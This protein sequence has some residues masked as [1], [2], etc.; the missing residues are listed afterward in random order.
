MNVG[1][2]DLQELLWP[3]A[4]MPER[5]YSA[6]GS[7]GRLDAYGNLCLSE[8][9]VF[10]GNAYFNAFFPTVWRDRARLG[11]VGLSCRA[12]GRVAMRLDGHCRDGSIATVAAWTQTAGMDQNVHWFW[13]DG[14]PLD[15]LRL[16]LHL[17]AE[18]EASVERVA[19]VTTRP[20][21]RDIRLTIGIVTHDREGCLARTLDA[22]TAG[23]GTLPELQR[24]VLVNQGP[25]FRDLPLREKVASPL[26]R[27]IVQPNLG[28]CGGFTRT[29]VEAMEDGGGATHLLLM[30]DDIRLD[31]RMIR[32]AIDFARQS[33]G[34]VAIGAQ[35][36]ELE[37][38]E[39]LQEAW[40]ALGKGWQPLMAG[41]GLDM[42]KPEG[43]CL[44]DEAVRPD[45]NGWWFCVIPTEAIRE[46]GLPV[47]VFIRG[48]DIEYGL[49]LGRGGWP[50]VALPGLAVWHAS[51]HYKHVG[52]AQYYEQRNLLIAAVAHRQREAM[53]PV[54]AVLG[55]CVHHLL[56][57]R[58]RAAAANALALSDFLAGPEA[59][60]GRN[61]ALRHREVA[62]WMDRLPR[63][64]RVDS[65][66]SAGLVR[67]EGFVAGRSTPLGAGK[68]VALILRILLTST[69]RP[70]QHLQ[71]GAPDPLAIQ[72]R[73]YLLA[74]DPGAR[75]C[76]A[77]RARR[78]VFLRI[79]AAAV[80]AAF[81]YWLFGPRSVER[82][83]ERL[84][85]LRSRDRW[86]R[87][88][89]ADHE[90]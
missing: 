85:A 56:A 34:S 22:I 65:P 57:H 41:T 51:T 17:R 23:A 27:L 68:A 73:P 38:P 21:Q 20:P 90:E 8:G 86:E 48:D 43:L 35:A 78:L 77:M 36:L 70:F 84:P 32:R 37:R 5:L 62:R 28:G 42:S 30:D 44:W 6:M 54:L 13:E 47:P 26:V 1:V 75:V 24:V 40:G 82:W 87:E 61:S 58:Y 89:T 66:E 49:R 55:R 46:I 64:E 52:L 67:L 18:E 63:P 76:L 74:L 29:M 50:V 33:V 25:A 39:H 9:E 59:A 83:A 45:Y 60:L 69:R 79:L 19:F 4:G 11:R 10:D 14:G 12:T 71:M 53:P 15:V 72:G 2:H 88:F 81:R 31:A 3:L 80:V 7:G 16:T